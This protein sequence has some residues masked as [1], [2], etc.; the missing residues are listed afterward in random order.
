M[1]G[2]P[3]LALQ[4]RPVEVDEVAQSPV[5]S[6]MPRTSYASSSPRPSPRSRIARVVGRHRALDL[7]ADGLAEAPPP[8]LLLDRHQQVVGLVLLDREVGVAG[9][10]EQV[11]LDDLHAAEQQVEVGLDDLVEQHEAV[12]LDLVEPR[13][14]LGDLDPGEAPL[15]GLR[16]AQPDRDRE[17]ERRDVRER[18]ARVDRERRQ[19]RVDL[20]DEPLAEGGVVL[21]DRGVLDDLD[22][23]SAASDLR[24]SAQVALWSGDELEDPVAG[25]GELLAGGPAV[26][27]RRR[28]PGVELLAQAGDR[29]WKN[30]SSML[31]KIVRKLT[32]SSS[33]L[34]GSRASNRTR[35]A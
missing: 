1:T 22:A 17:A 35:A 20:V 4:V 21:G 32:R 9:D 6:S 19:D 12:R 24:I 16:V 14:D 29:I 11:V 30:S 5:R 8:E 13:Q 2:S 33:G 18:V 10:P 3:R 28:R 23:G 31:A 25:R 34:R 27:R 26:G 7:E 15:V